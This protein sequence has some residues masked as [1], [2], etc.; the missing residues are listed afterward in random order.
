MIKNSLILV[1]ITFV[2]NISFYSTLTHSNEK[3]LIWNKGNDDISHMKGTNSNFKKGYN[4]LQQAK[5]FN[6]KGKVQKAIKRFNDSI[7]FFLLAN[8]INPDEP[9]T[10]YYLGFAYRNVG[11]DM[12][13]EIYYT[14]GLEINP[15]HINININFGKLYVETN[16]INKAKKILTTLE[17][18]N[19]KE[20]E[21]LKSLI[22]KN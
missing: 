13:A 9:N 16:Q 7:K 15:Q 5:K 12:M 19:C 8:N 4:A 22:Q 14:Q 17:G 20:F 21:E 2:I 3:D 6:E 11:D 10:L 18:C 1:L